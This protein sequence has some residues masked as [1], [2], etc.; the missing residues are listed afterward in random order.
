MIT[1]NIWAEYKL[2]HYRKSKDSKTK[3]EYVITIVENIYYRHEISNIETDWRTC[4]VPNKR[5]QLVFLGM[6]VKENF[7]YKNL[8]FDDN[9]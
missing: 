2:T 6:V 1:N 9:E 7:S 8:N 3:K 5:E 4:K